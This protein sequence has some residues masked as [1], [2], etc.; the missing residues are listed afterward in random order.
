MPK[1]IK[2]APPQQANLNELWGGKGKKKAK[3]EDASND[4]QD[5]SKSENK[6]VAMEEA[7]KKPTEGSFNIYFQL[8]RLLMLYTEKPTYPKRRSKSPKSPSRSTK[9][10]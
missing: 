1:G 8:Y 4:A 2:T 9:G 5:A 7:V 3:Q 6:D 10:L